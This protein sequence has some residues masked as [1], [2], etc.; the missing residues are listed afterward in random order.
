[1]LWSKKCNNWFQNVVWWK[2]K[3]AENGNNNV[4]VLEYLLKYLKIILKYSY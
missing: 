2:Y 1:M 3:V 4:E